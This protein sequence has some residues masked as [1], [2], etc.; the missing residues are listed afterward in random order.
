MGQGSALN[1]GEKLALR[2]DWVRT[3]GWFHRKPIQIE[4]KD[5]GQIVSRPREW[6]GSGP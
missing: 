3:F 1:Y 4:Q 5:V 6:R 2:S